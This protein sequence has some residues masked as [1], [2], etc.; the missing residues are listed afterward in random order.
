MSLRMT[1]EERETFLSGVHVGI[2]SLAEAG[3]G[4]LAVPIWYGYEPGGDLWIV[5]ESQ[6]RKG[7]LLSSAQRFS[8][9]IQTEE[10]PYKY[11]SI[12]GPIASIAAA[13]LERHLRPLAH[14]YLGKE[15]GDGYIEATGGA[16]S[17]AQSIVVRMR[18]ERWLTTDY[19][20]Q[21]GASG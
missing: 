7:K 2:I 17:R 9:C 6:S 1:R 8:L 16:G 20:K 14:R 18:P 21:F 5:T 11:V 15:I 3:R 4:P 13:D 12:E 10:P 19:S